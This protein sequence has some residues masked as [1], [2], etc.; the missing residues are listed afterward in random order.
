MTSK[1][2]WLM[3]L[4]ITFSV[5]ILYYTIPL[6]DE[7]ITSEKVVILGNIV[8]SVSDNIQ[9][10]NAIEHSSKDTLIPFKIDVSLHDK[11]KTDRLRAQAVL[12]SLSNQ[13]KNIKHTND[14][15]EDF[16][17]GGEIMIGLLHTA[18]S[19]DWEDFIQKA[20]LFEELGPEAKN[21]ALNLAIKNAAPFDIILEFVTRG[22]EFN[23]DTIMYLSYT[24][25]VA[26]TQELMSIGLNLHLSD[27][28]G[29]NGVYFSSQAYSQSMFNLFI[30]YGVTVKPSTQGLDPLDI[31]LKRSSTNSNSS[32]F[33]RKLLENGAPIQQSHIELI[34]ELKNKNL[35]YY[36]K[37][38]SLNPEL[39]ID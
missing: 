33:I 35:D 31:V 25:N 39:S 37:V 32:Y 10:K 18:V 14:N 12:N 28:Y 20:E 38:I 34:K 9:T 16:I 26:L 27:Q 17:A 2:I 22:A 7:K 6:F 36:K 24:D 13:M 8:D 21:R 23:S 11:E 5:S 15:K 30:S 29:R 1:R 19:K 3:L 4:I